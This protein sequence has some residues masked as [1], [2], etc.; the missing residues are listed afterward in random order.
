MDYNWFLSATAQSTAAIIGIFSAFIITKLINNQ[1]THK[2]NVG[3]FV[4]LEQESVRLKGMNNFDK[5][6]HT[7][8]EE[9]RNNII[10]EKAKLG[11]EI[12][13]HINK[14][15]HFI[16]EV[17]QN[18]ESSNLISFSI[19]SLLFL[20]FIGVILPLC[21][22]PSDKNFQTLLLTIISVIFTAIMIFFFIVNLRMK[23]DKDKIDKIREYCDINYYYKI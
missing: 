21:K 15:N 20:F 13:S 8:N 17:N 12:K 11:V 4:L 22:L 6:I 9:I 3:L 7:H 19:I 16:S 10:L 2:N 18:S 5:D 23:Y 1:K 14:I